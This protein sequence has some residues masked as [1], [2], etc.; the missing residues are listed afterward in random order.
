M[1]EEL[2]EKE[3]IE[4]DDPDDDVTL[5]NTDLNLP[6]GG[7]YFRVFLQ[8]STTTVDLCVPQSSGLSFDRLVEFGVYLSLFGSD[9]TV[10]DVVKT[11]L[12]ELLKKSKSK[13]EVN[14]E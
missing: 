3:R 11:D 14:S 4:A 8:T 5:Q 9:E 12:L 10:R 6:S 2:Q 1:N 7:I 13:K